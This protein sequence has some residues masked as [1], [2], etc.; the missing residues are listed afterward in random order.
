MG[1]SIESPHPW[2]QGQVRWNCRHVCKCF[3]FNECSVFSAGGV[4]SRRAF[5]STSAVFTTRSTTLFTCCALHN[6]LLDVDG[7][8]AQ[9]EHGT[10]GDW[11]GSWGLHD[12]ADAARF[13]VARDT[14]LSGFDDV[15]DDSSEEGGSSSGEARV[16]RQMDLGDFRGALI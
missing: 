9:W 10:Q 6:W 4:F 13:M 14:D 16:V 8:D 2:P 1:S 5:A 11:E 3:I 15:N 7:L 12:E